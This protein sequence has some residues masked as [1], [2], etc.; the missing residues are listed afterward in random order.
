MKLVLFLCIIKASAYGKTDFEIT[1]RRR[2]F[3]KCKK[4]EWAQLERLG[5]HPFFYTLTF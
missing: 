3:I 2:R 1:I 5:S 4:Q